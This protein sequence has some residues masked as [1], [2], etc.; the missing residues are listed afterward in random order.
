MITGH[1]HNSSATF[2]T[3][4]DLSRF[5]ISHW[6]TRLTLTDLYYF[7]A[8]TVGVSSFLRLLARRAQPGRPGG[9]HTSLDPLLGA[10]HV[11]AVPVSVQRDLH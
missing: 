4:V 3:N 2:G 9:A 10:V 11:A 6:Y 1:I 8:Q 5:G 7:V